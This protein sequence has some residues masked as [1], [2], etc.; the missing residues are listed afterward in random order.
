MELQSL[1]SAELFQGVHLDAF[2]MDFN[3]LQQEL[4]QG[5]SSLFR[6]P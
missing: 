5:S 1:K 6:F 4:E 2:D 3:Q